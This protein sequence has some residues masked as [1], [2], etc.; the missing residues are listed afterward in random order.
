MHIRAGSREAIDR[1]N[2]LKAT[3][4]PHDYLLVAPS[5]GTSW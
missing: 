4:A 2:D 5:G 3:L 1:G